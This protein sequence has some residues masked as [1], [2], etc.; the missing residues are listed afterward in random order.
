MIGFELYMRGYRGKK[1]DGGCSY[2]VSMLEI[3][4][5]QMSFSSVNRSSLDVKHMA[6]W[7][8]AENSAQMKLWKKQ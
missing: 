3:L 4:M 5:S 8:V 2:C 1:K 7:L 6:F